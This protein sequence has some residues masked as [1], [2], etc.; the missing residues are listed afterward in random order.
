MPHAIN[1]R[2][3]FEQMGGPWPKSSEDVIAQLLTEI[4]EQEPAKYEKR[5]K[6]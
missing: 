2:Q 6:P 3:I 4:G 5:K 1:G